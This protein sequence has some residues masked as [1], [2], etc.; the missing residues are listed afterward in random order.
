M[1][2]D[3]GNGTL[4]KIYE[5]SATVLSF[6]LHHFISCHDKDTMITHLRSYYVTLFLHDYVKIR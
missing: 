1:G 3:N 5:G 2:M 4:D 6:F